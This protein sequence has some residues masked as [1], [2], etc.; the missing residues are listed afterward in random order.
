MRVD[1]RNCF[2]GGGARL[3]RLELLQPPLQFR[4]RRTARGQNS[5]SVFFPNLKRATVGHRRKR[6]ARKSS[7]AAVACSGGKRHPR[8]SDCWWA[9]QATVIPHTFGVGV[10]NCLVSITAWT[11][12]LPNCNAGGAPPRRS[13]GR[14]LWYAL[15]LAVGLAARLLS[16]VVAMSARVLVDAARFPAF[17]SLADVGSV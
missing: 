4:H 13:R 15:Y 7:V 14:Q 17:L 8:R 11:A 6:C 2:C 3:R 9:S 16:R 10:W 12:P 1:A 5:C